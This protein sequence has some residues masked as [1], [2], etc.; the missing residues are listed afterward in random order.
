MRLPISPILHLFGDTAGYFVLLIP[1]LFQPNSGG[2]PV[3]P[4]HPCWVNVSRYLKLF[5]REII[6]EVFQ[7]V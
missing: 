7:P 2:V 6:F 3:G 5:G 4:H 1:T